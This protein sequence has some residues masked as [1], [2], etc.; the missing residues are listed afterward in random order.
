M[1]II[2]K[3]GYRVCLHCGVISKSSDLL[4]LESN[5]KLCKCCP[6]CSVPEHVDIKD[7]NIIGL[8]KAQDL[9]RIA[10]LKSKESILTPEI[11][12]EYDKMYDKALIPHSIRV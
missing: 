12:S 9:F 8:L 5:G 3:K 6:S 1:M 10:E 11:I 4:E 2:P 7:G